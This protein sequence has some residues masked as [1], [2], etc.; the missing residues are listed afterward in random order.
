M[1]GKASA[2]A[3]QQLLPSKRQATR[4]H[5]V[6]AP[7]VS[8]SEREDLN[9]GI[10]NRAWGWNN[11]GALRGDHRALPSAAGMV[12]ATIGKDFRAPSMN[13]FACITAYDRKARRPFL[14][15]LRR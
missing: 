7:L 6:V 2:V 13:D 10:I 4:S 1:A 11:D 5:A 8:G 14:H 12:I 9:H 3:V 15:L